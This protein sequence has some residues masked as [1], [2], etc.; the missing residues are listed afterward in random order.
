MRLLA[1]DPK[2]HTTPMH[3][4]GDLRQAQKIKRVTKW[5]AR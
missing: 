4:I 2:A 1:A 5:A 3:K